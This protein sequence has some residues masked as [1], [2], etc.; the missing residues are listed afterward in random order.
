MSIAKQSFAEHKRSQTEFRNKTITSECFA[1]SNLRNVKEL[2]YSK[3]R[4][5]S[6]EDQQTEHSDVLYSLSSDWSSSQV[7]ASPAKRSPLLSSFLWQGLQ[8]DDVI[9]QTVLNSAVSTFLQGQVQ[10]T[11]VLNL[12]RTSEW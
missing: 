12:E 6:G 2:N 1:L 5:I 9:I 10:Q 3:F 4:M 7:L 11:G 8:N